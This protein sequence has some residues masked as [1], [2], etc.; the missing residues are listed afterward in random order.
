M[1]E[2]KTF[3]R[4]VSSF[5]KS[6]V[7]FEKPVVGFEKNNFSGCPKEGANGNWD[8][9]RGNSKWIPDDNYVPCGQHTNP[10]GKT[11]KELKKD[12]GFDGIVFIEGEADFLEVA[13]E[14][15]EIEDFSTDRDDNFV[16]ADEALA[17]KLKCSPDE[18]ASMRKEERLT[19]HERKDQKTIDLVP[20]DIHGNV[21]HSG[22]IAEAK[23]EV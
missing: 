23:K 7:G 11:W 16:A 10:E 22:G 9:E 13:K 17:E 21:R 3:Q 20:M 19:W 2:L 18:I 8:G 12:Y 5:E 4:G 15:V 1:F 14:T 6:V